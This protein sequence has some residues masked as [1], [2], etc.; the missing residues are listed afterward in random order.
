MKTDD[1]VF[2]NFMAIRI[3]KCHRKLLHFKTVFSFMHRLWG[4]GKDE[5]DTIC[6]KFVCLWVILEKFCV[7]RQ[8]ARQQWLYY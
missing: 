1:A 5:E 8:N 3:I 2:G 4:A 7:T 6:R